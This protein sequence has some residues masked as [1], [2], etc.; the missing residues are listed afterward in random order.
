METHLIKLPT[1]SFYADFSCRGSLEFGSECCNRG[2]T[3][4]STWQSHSLSLCGL[5]LRGWAVVAPRRFHFTNSTCSSNRSEIWQTDMLE[6]LHHMMVPRWKSLSSSVKPF[7]C[8]C[9]CMEIAWLCTQFYTPVN[10]GCGW[11]G[12]IH[13]FKGVFTYFWPRSVFLMSY[14]ICMVFKIKLDWLW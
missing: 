7:Y 11:N 14:H 12:Q 1:K 9:L 4:F 5:P 8:Q 3:H 10:N 6:R 13:S 2:Q